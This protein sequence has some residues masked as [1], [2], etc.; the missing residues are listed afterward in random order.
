[1]QA[2]SLRDLGPPAEGNWELTGKVCL[3][4]PNSASPINQQICPVETR[5]PWPQPTEDR[6]R[7]L[8]EIVPQANTLKFGNKSSFLI[9]NNNSNYLKSRVTER[10]SDDKVICLLVQIPQ[11]KLGPSQAEARSWDSSRAPMRVAGA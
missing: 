5:S 4:S 11:A 10:D 6:E 9:Q 8:L 7:P 2:K 1:M 3:S